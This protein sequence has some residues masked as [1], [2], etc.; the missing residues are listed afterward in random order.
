M[1]LQVL[2]TGSIDFQRTP[3]VL[4]LLS[5]GVIKPVGWANLQAMGNK[6]LSESAIPLFI[7]APLFGTALIRNKFLQ[8]PTDLA[9]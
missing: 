7:A 4:Q 9:P 6:A 8:L 1:S 2:Y 5:M 3:E